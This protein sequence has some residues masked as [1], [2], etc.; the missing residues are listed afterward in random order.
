[1][2]TDSSS[3]F[4]IERALSLLATRDVRIDY[5]D[6]V[7]NRAG[8]DLSRAAAWL[9]VRIEDDRELD[10]VALFRTH[11]LDRGLLD[12][13][14]AELEGKG[15]VARVP[16]ENPSVTPYQPTEAGT[17]V[18]TRLIAARREH[19]T[20]FLSEWAPEKRVE[21]ANSIESLSRQLVPDAAP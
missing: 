11:G 9:L 7:V 8:V 5:I 15:L 2:P 6:R 16:G 1:M 18:L 17:E 21:L 19:L 3:L 20:G 14:L 4:R 13:T 12:R 10:P